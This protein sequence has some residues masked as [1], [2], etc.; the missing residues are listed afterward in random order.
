MEAR[1]GGDS[2]GGEGCSGDNGGD[3]SSG[4]DGDADTFCCNSCGVG[5]TG[6]DGIVREKENGKQGRRRKC[7]LL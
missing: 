7:W 1:G 2:G 6:G 5:W 3:N 4:G